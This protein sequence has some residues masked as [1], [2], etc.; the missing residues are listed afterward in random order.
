MR[1]GRKR[2][3]WGFPFKELSIRISR[4]SCHGEKSLERAQAAYR[5]DFER[6]NEACK[7]APKEKRIEISYRNSKSPHQIPG[8]NSCASVFCAKSANCEVQMLQIF[9]HC[10]KEDYVWQVEF[11]GPE[12]T[13][14]QQRERIIKAIKTFVPH[15]SVISQPPRQTSSSSH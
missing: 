1:N 7:K 9:F 8:A 14:S 6:L 5:S 10:A 11:T 4:G 12:P 2:V 15:L 13:Y 3:P